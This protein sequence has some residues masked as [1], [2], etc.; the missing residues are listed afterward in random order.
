MKRHPSLEQPNRWAEIMDRNESWISAA[1][2][3]G[4]YAV[5]STLLV[6]STLGIL[7]SIV[8]IAEPPDGSHG[9]RLIATAGL[10][11]SLLGFW[12]GRRLCDD[13]RVRPGRGS[14]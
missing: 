11:V 6:A 14:R 2:M 13:Y 4:F 9:D 7:V 8:F 3:W 12:T 5:G 10:V 1:A